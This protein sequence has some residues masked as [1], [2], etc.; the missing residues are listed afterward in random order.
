MASGETWRQVFAHG[1]IYE[2]S[3]SAMF[4]VPIEQ[5]TK[6]SPLRAKGK[7]AELALGY[8]GAAGGGPN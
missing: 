8:Q 6:D 1:K 7:V 3:A 4:G 5:I 2:A